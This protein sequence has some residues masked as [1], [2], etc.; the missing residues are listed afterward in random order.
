MEW[1]FTYRYDIPDG[2]G[3]PHFGLV[4]LSFLIAFLLGTILISGYY[5]KT[6]EKH[7]KAIKVT[8][9]WIVVM[10]EVVKQVLVAAMGKYE[11]GMLVFHLCGMSI[12]FIFI[13]TYWPNRWTAAFLYS[14]SIPGAVAALLFCDWNLY[15]VAN[16]FSLQSFFIH[17]FEMSYPILLV[18]SGELKPRF[19]ELWRSVVYLAIVV[20]PIYLF[21]K[22]F[23]TN[24][25][26]LNDTVPDSPIAF[27]E[28]FMGNPGYIFGFAGLLFLVWFFMYLPFWLKHRHDSPK[29][30]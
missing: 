19:H 1:F 22:Q 23:G 13:H 2:L 7:R 4:H 26:F 15:P 18:R 25:F 20:P 16:F 11:P 17:F 14:M 9:A 29:S 27:L 5:K 24:F 3:W 10:L 8:Y 30:A 28:T 12:F 6:D 21:N